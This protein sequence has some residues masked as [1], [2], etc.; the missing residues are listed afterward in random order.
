M[1]DQVVKLNCEHTLKNHPDLKKRA[2]FA[3]DY[4]NAVCPETC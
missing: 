2:Y 1:G 4:F 3:G